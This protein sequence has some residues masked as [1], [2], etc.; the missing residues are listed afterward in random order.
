MVWFIDEIIQNHFF[1]EQLWSVRL[2]LRF[3]GLNLLFTCVVLVI[4]DLLICS[5]SLKLDVSFLR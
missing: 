3:R 1:K 5:A 2:R 4:I